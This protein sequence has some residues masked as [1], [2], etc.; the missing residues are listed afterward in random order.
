M[1]DEILEYLNS[2]GMQEA[3]S[4]ASFGD[5]ERGGSGPSTLTTIMAAADGLAPRLSTTSEISKINPSPGAS[6]STAT[7]QH[8]LAQIQARLRGEQQTGV[9]S[10]QLTRDSTAPRSPFSGFSQ[11]GSG[12]GSRRGKSPRSNAYVTGT[13]PIGNTMGTATKPLPLP[14]QAPI[15]EYPWVRQPSVFNRV[16]GVSLG[17]QDR[18]KFLAALAERDVSATMPLPPPPSRPCIHRLSG[19][20]VSLPAGKEEDEAGVVHQSTLRRVQTPLET[21]SATIS[22]RNAE[23]LRRRLQEEQA[24]GKVNNLIILFFRCTWWIYLFRC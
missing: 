15:N 21:P 3:M 16:R 18:A 9:G 19:P 2:E 4:Q 7:G 12:E 6:L 10:P 5:A 20:V 13:T 22:G 1:V 23:L 8:L 24:K 14:G 11:S 17:T